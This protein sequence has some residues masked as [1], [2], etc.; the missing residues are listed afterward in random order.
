MV[1][2]E[3]L[4]W[5]SEIAATQKKF[6]VKEGGDVDLECS[7]ELARHLNMQLEFSFTSANS[8]ATKTVL[9]YNESNQRVGN[10][11][12]TPNMDDNTCHLEIVNFSEA[13]AGQ[14]DCLMVLINSHTSYNQDRSNAIFLAAKNEETKNQDRLYYIIIPSLTVIGLVIILIAL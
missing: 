2:D 12:V 5:E 6:Q 14:Y 13:D 9:C 3:V 11:V 7:L 10:W 1:N 8:N 4:M